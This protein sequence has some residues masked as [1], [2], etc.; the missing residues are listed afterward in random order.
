[1]KNL[2]YVFFVLCFFSVYADND[3]QDDDE[4]SP[5]TQQ[6]ELGKDKDDAFAPEVYA[7]VSDKAVKNAV[8]FDGAR[9]LIGLGMTMQKFSSSMEEEEETNTKSSSMN[10]FHLTA[11]LEYAKSS[12]KGLLFSIGA[13]CD[14]SKKKKIE[15]FLYK[16][17]SGDDGVW[18][19][20][21]FTPSLALKCGYK[22]KS[23]KLV[24]FAKAGASRLSL[25]YTYTS[26]SDEN[27]GEQIT[28]KI[29]PIVPMIGIGA[30]K[31]I[32]KKWG[33][34]AEINFPIKRKNKMK[35][36]GTEHSIKA[37][38]INIRIML[39]LALQNP[40]KDLDVKGSML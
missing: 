15:D 24:V 26:D 16:P 35:I 29:N 7:D 32:N 19:T 2:A 25:S 27:N 20:N 5:E 38:G 10:I 9:G 3:S 8:S 36:D 4:F 28:K 40:P 22:I 34:L 1:M 6:N 23:Q 31:K 18:E 12:K 37:G 39:S 21:M 14:I 30:E 11:G 33:C 13:L 17:T